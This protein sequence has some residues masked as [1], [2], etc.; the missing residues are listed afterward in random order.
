[1]EAQV[2]A[3]GIGQ[4]S[5]SHDSGRLE[6]SQELR[7]VTENLCARSEAWRAA[8]PAGSSEGAA[9]PRAEGIAFYR[10]ACDPPCSAEA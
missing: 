9:K 5:P 8:L 2:V 4:T 6:A 1:M 10:A 3:L 7:P